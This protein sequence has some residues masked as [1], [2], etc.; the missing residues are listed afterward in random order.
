MANYLPRV[1][2]EGSGPGGSRWDDGAN[3]RVPTGAGSGIA[4][5]FLQTRPEF[6]FRRYFLGPSIPV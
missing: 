5:L 6:R 3:W 4:K 1:S 2:L